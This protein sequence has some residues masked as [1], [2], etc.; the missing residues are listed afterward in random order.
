MVIMPAKVAPELCNWTAN[1]VQWREL[2][3]FMV[4]CREVFHHQEPARFQEFAERLDKAKIP[5]T[6]QNA[7]AELARPY[8]NKH[9]YTATL[10]NASGIRMEG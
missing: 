1:E 6:V 10:F 7:V 3:V 2:E 8:N 5:W 9:Y 4:H